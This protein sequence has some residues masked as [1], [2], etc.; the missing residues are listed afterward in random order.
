[1][2]QLEYSLSFL[3]CLP[4]KT[5]PIFLNICL[6]MHK[7]Q[8]PGALMGKPSWCI[9][10]N[11]C[12]AL[13]NCTFSE[14]CKIYRP[15]KSSQQVSE[16]TQVTHQPCDSLLQ[17]NFLLKNPRTKEIRLQGEQRSQEEKHPRKEEAITNNCCHF[18]FSF[19]PFLCCNSQAHREA[20]SVFQS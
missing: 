7:I 17:G 18:Q 10:T 19:F 2:K 4:D 15:L 16:N 12:V 5:S 8:T 3:K 13:I 11:I 1:M 9:S 20:R 6:I 14:L